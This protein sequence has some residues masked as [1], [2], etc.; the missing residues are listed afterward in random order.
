MTKEQSGEKRRSEIAKAVMEQRRWQK[1]Q[2]EVARKKRGNRDQSGKACSRMPA[3][4]L[5]AL[6]LSTLAR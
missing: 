3:D 4:G 6:S 1:Q 5:S 2:D